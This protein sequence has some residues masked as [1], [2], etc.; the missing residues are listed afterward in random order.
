MMLRKKGAKIILKP[1]K[2]PETPKQN[3]KVGQFQQPPTITLSEAP[4]F[5][6]PKPKRKADSS[7]PKMQCSKANDSTNLSDKTGKK[8]AGRSNK[9]KNDII[10]KI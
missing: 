4:D 5:K 3:P 1:Q 9:L 7:L 8:L 10:S 2:H 6:K